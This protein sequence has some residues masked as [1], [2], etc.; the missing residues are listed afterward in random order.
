MAIHW[1][2]PFISLRSGTLYTLCIYDAEYSG[3]PIPLKAGAEPFVTEENDDEDEFT[4]IRTQT[5]YMRIIDDGKDANGNAFNWKDLIPKNDTDRPL[6]LTH[7]SG[8]NVTVDWVGFM[9]AQNFGA[10]LYYTPQEREYPIQ[11]V[12]SITSG[13][14]VNYTQTQIQNFAYLLKQI[15]DVIPTALR[16][17]NFIIQ[18]GSDAQAWLLKRIDWQNF[19]TENNDGSLSARYNLYQCLEDMCRFWGWTAR[20]CGQSMYLLCSDDLNESKLLKL[21]YSQLET[22]ATGVA[23]GSVN[24]EYTEVTLSGDIFANIYQDDFMQR[25]HNKATVKADGN[26]GDDIVL[27]IADYAADR[28]LQQ[29]WQ[30][31]IIEDNDKVRFTN[32]LY[33]LTFPL[34]KV[35]AVENAASLNL[36]DYTTKEAVISGIVKTSA[37]TYD[38][39]IM[40]KQAYSAGVVIASLETEYEHCFSHDFIE[41]NGKIFQNT[42]EY[43]DVDE[44][45]GYGLSSMYVRI[46]IGRSRETAKWLAGDNIW[47]D[48][49]TDLQAEI[50]TKQD[51]FR[52]KIPVGGGI[53]YRRYIFIND[54]LYGKLFIDFLGSSDIKE[55]SGSRNF[56][57]KNPH[58]KLYQDQLMLALLGYWEYF[59]TTD[60][61][62]PVDVREYM[63]NN[64]NNVRDEVYTD[65]IYA[66]N[67]DMAF[68]YGVIINADGSYMWHALYNGLEE[69]PEQHLANRI[70]NYWK[71]AR[72]RLC[73]ELRANAVQHITP[74]YMVTIDHSHC[75]PI[76]ISHKWCD[77]ILKLTMLEI[78]EI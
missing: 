37:N 73:I 2:I 33:N 54:P 61:K 67:N 38:R 74:E 30:Q 68:G 29:G 31:Y 18:G 28:L 10:R 42:V 1:T 76:A 65:C 57:I 7:A 50:G 14:D 15:I 72:R 59:D 56:Q 51:A 70:V 41:L 19:I 23:A 71:Q 44:S 35:S 66:T 27:G 5:G 47:S 21:T 13:T 53:A 6:V 49:P 40:I 9:Q 4:P 48:T 58:V 20:T 11:C 12:L 22:M 62:D 64:T 34:F 46:G 63:A 36:A 78:P 3:S 60:F 75:H 39:V 25:G 16:P 43:E 52:V 24:D 17:L 8:N 55:H 32:D 26:K 77:E 69:Y 45:T